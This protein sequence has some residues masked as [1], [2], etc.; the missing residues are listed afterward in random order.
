M[1]AFWL[2]DLD[3]RLKIT[4]RSM[5]PQRIAMT[6]NPW[7]IPKVLGRKIDLNRQ[8]K[9]N[10]RRTQKNHETQ[11]NFRFW[12]LRTCGGVVGV[13]TRPKSGCVERPRRDLARRASP[14]EPHKREG[15]AAELS[16]HCTPQDRKRLVLDSTFLP[17]IDSMNPV[18]RNQARAER[19]RERRLIAGNRI[20]IFPGRI[21]CNQASL[22]HTTTN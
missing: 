21:V 10:D 15:K 2:L 12:L 14:S 16:A 20:S 9:S 17:D 11:E 4:W 18:R 22:H 3:C 7:L 8:T 13:L 5:R 1:Q 19:S 6:W